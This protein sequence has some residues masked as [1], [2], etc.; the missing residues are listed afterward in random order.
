MSWASEAAHVFNETTGR[1]GKRRIMLQ[2]TLLLV[3]RRGG[4][5]RKKPMPKIGPR[6]SRN[7]NLTP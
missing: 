7:P 3:A 5:E 1:E 6:F 4:G 2:W